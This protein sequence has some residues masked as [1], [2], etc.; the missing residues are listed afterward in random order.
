MSTNVT[1]TELIKA[2]Y[3]RLKA[4]TNGFEVIPVS[5]FQDGFKLQPGHVMKRK[6]GIHFMGGSRIEVT[7]GVDL[8]WS[9]GI[10]NYHLAWHKDDRILGVQLSDGLL[11]EL[12]TI[13]PYLKNYRF[14]TELPGK[15][16]DARI[17]TDLPSSTIAIQTPSGQIKYAAWCGFIIK[18]SLESR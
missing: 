14:E 11:S 7:G 10:Y 4:N 15:V 1:R 6:L 12:D 5:S 2:I 13:E 9:V 3:N 18:Y 16:C 17:I 8:E